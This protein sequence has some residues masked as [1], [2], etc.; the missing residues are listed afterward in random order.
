MMVYKNIKTLLKESHWFFVML[1]LLI[2]TSNVLSGCKEKEKVTAS[3][4]VG[5]CEIY[6]KMPKDIAKPLDINY[7]NKA[8]LLGITVDKTSQNQLKISYYWQLMDELGAYNKAFI[9]FTDID[10][11]ILFVHVNDFCQNRPFTE[12]KGKFLKETN[13]VNIPN[14]AIGK[15]LDIK[16]GIYAPT[17]KTDF[18][19]KIISAGGVPVDDNNTRAVV[20]KLG[21]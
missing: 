9:H 4:V 16:I 21:L 1:V 18:R 15:K 8:K 6:D 12:L 3:K 20:E 14:T 11:K 17:L 2:S 19:L 7:G 13:I 10:N 5:P